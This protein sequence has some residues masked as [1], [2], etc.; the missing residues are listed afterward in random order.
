MPDQFRSAKTDS[1][2]NGD[3]QIKL[4]VCLFIFLQIVKVHSPIF[5]VLLLSQDKTLY[6]IF[7]EALDAIPANFR[8]SQTWN[9]HRSTFTSSD[10]WMFD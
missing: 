5:Y 9:D 10:C 2:D 1:K 8:I 3:T 4:P 7:F 6:F